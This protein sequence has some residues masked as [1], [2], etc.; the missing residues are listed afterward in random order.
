MDRMMLK[1]SSRDSTTQFSKSD[2][3]LSGDLYEP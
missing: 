1:N 3:K 2:A